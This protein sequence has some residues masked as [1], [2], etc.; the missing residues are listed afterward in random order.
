MDL[1]DFERDTYGKLYLQWDRLRSE[2][3]IIEAGIVA[4]SKPLSSHPE[5]SQPEMLNEESSV[6]LLEVK[7]REHQEW[8]EAQEETNLHDVRA[9]NKLLM[10]KKK[11]LRKYDRQL[12]EIEKKHHVLR[13]NKSAF[14]HQLNELNKQLGE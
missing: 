11:M 10:L 12:S 6:K 7:L 2:V 4:L 13:E 14:E 9:G 5:L 8:L 1:M 3:R